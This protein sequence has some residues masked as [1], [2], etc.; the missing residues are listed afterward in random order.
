MG[1]AKKIPLGH[2]P[3]VYSDDAVSVPEASTEYFPHVYI[4]DVSGLEALPNKGTVTFEY[5]LKER[6]KRNTERGGTSEEHTDVELDLKSIVDYAAAKEPKEKKSPREEVE[7]V[8][9]GLDAD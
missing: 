4:S 2:K 7:E 9:S 3:E 5:V 8:F 1:M 6:T